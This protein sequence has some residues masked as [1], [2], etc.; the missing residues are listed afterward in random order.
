MTSTQVPFRMAKGAMTAT[1]DTRWEESGSHPTLNTFAG[2]S[3]M[4]LQSAVT[5]QVETAIPIHDQA[6]RF[7]GKRGDKQDGK[8]NGLGIGKDGDPANTLTKNDRHAVAQTIGF[9]HTQGLDCQPSTHHFPTLRAEG[10]GQAVHQELAVRRLTPIECERLQGFPDN[11]T[12][13]PWRK[14]TQENCPDGPRF[15]CMGNSMAVPVMRWIGEG[16]ELV[17]R[18]PKEGKA[19]QPAELG[20]L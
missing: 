8:G 11:W 18:I 12:Q 3:E 16:I 10:N 7:A 20:W 14:K 5:V 13:I 2:H 6:T 17:N 4:R 1:D 19:P 9:S 15:K